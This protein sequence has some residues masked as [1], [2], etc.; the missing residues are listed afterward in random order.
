[1]DEQNQRRIGHK[2]GNLNLRVMTGTAIDF[3]VS[4][5]AIYV[6]MDALSNLFKRQY[7]STSAPAPITK[8]V[9]SMGQQNHHKVGHETRD[10]NLRAVT[11]TAIGL[12][13][14][15][16]A[17]Y[18]TV[19]GLFNLFKRQYPS[20]SVPSRITTPGRLPSQPRLQTNPAYDLQQFR[21]AESAKLNSYGWIDK[22]AGVLRI[23]I[24]R[25]IDLLAQ[26]GLPARG[27]RNEIGGKTP[28]QMRQE[29]AEASHR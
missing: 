19:G 26:R 10:I 27:N 3:V 9:L 6:A 25:A 18:V 21:D 8:G 16:I 4:V 29:K 5:V 23:P 15:A 1:M 13:I 20:A 7:R 14:S 22:S 12:V 28:L 24:D 17:M 2:A 11:W